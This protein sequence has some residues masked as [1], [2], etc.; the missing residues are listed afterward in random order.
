MSETLSLIFNMAWTKE[1]YFIYIFRSDSV[2]KIKNAN[3]NLYGQTVNKQMKNN[4]A[5]HNCIFI[6]EDEKYEVISYER[7]L[8]LYQIRKNS[9]KEFYCKELFYCKVSLKY[10]EFRDYAEFITIFT[11]FHL[12][13]LLNIYIS[14]SVH[15]YMKDH[16]IWEIK[17]LYKK[18]VDIT[19]GSTLATTRTSM[20]MKFVDMKFVDMDLEEYGS[21]HDMLSPLI[22]N[23]FQ[24]R[25]EGSIGINHEDSLT[26]CRITKMGKT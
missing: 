18:L 17:K 1:E 19:F 10:N 12:D 22:T 4:W 9:N 23:R 13:S 21:A 3:I 11:S 24:L 2:N 26:C 5:K 7:T 16:G 14:F 8:E 6:I 25:I 20:S 15:P